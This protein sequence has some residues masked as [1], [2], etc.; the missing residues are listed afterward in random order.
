LGRREIKERDNTL[1]PEGTWDIYAARPPNGGLA[2]S[3]EFEKQLEAARAECFLPS[4]S[5]EA[6]NGADH[7]EI[8]GRESI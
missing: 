5:S 7:T 3:S 6:I 2:H 4:D 8:S 1:L